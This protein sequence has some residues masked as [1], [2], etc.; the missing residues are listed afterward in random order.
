MNRSGLDVTEARRVIEIEDV[1]EADDGV[2]LEKGAQ[3]SEDLALDLFVF[4]SRLDH[5]IAVTELVESR[6]DM[7]AVENRPA[8]RIVH[9][10]LGHLARQVA[11][12][13]RERGVDALLGDVVEGDLQSR[14]RRDLGDAGAHLPGADDAD[15]LDVE[16]HISVQQTAEAGRGS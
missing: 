14:L 1:F 2:G 6:G 11:I 10:P 16:C 15:R 7:D 3:P 5:Q 13:G 8:L 9:L 12:D 4:G